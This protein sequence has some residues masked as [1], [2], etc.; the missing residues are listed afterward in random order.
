M[1]RDNPRCAGCSRSAI[2]CRL[3]DSTMPAL[4]GR[5]KPRR[6]GSVANGRDSGAAVSS[7]ILDAD[8]RRTPSGLLVLVLDRLRVFATSTTTT[9]SV[10]EGSLNWSPSLWLSLDGSGV[11]MPVVLDTGF[12]MDGFRF[13]VDFDCS[14]SVGVS[15][16]EGRWMAVSEVDSASSRAALAVSVM[17]SAGAGRSVE[18]QVASSCRAMKNNVFMK[19]PS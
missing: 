17:A 15:S 19:L 5:S 11:G 7:C 1:A 12:S 13:A 2:D 3:L 9:W 10:K 8:R 18:R 14:R 16:G 6:S 4:N